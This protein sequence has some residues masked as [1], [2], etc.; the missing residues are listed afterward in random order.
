MSDQ[1]IQNQIN[2]LNNV[3]ALAEHDPSYYP[4]ILDSV[5]S[6]AERKELSLRQWCS[7]LF[8]SALTSENVDEE[9]KRGFCLKLVDSVVNLLSD[10]DLHLQRNCI[11]LS[12]IIYP[13]GFIHVA[14]NPSEKSL[15]SQLEKMKA[16]I[17]SLWD[18]SHFGVKAESIK[19]AQQ[20]IAIQMFNNDN[21]NRD[22]RL[23][24]NAPKN[25]GSSNSFSLSSVPPNHPLIKPS[26]EA[27]AQGLLDR[28][29][30]VFTSPVFKS[31]IIIATLFALSALMKTRPSTA[32]KIIPTVLGFNFWTREAQA[33]SEH[34]AEMQ[35]RFV[36]KGLR[37]FVL[38]TVK[39]VGNKFEHMVHGYLND[40]GKPGYRVAQAIGSRGST[41]RVKREPSDYDNH[42][43]KKQIAQPLKEQSPPV[44]TLP[45]A[46]S[47]AKASSPG[48]I[49]F[50][51]NS[52]IQSFKDLYSLVG[53]GSASENF[54]V[55]Q[56]NLDMAI[57]IAMASIAAANPQIYSKA[58]DTVR[59]RFETWNKN[60]YNDM[61]DRYSNS[62]YNNG[63]SGPRDNPILENDLSPSDKDAENDQPSAETIAAENAE[64]PG[65][66]F[67]SDEEDE[68]D[69]DG[70]GFGDVYGENSGKAFVLPTPSQLNTSEKVK[71]I[72][73]ILVRMISYEKATEAGEEGTNAIIGEITDVN[74]TE[75]ELGLN[76]R[77]AVREWKKNTWVALISRLLTRGFGDVISNEKLNPTYTKRPEYQ[78]HVKS[79]ESITKFIREKL[80]KYC[81]E[82][83]WDRLDIALE[84][85]N[86]EWFHEF[87]RLDSS[88][89]PK[90][91]DGENSVYFHY[92]GLM[93]DSIIPLVDHRY[94]AEFLRLLS[95][96]PEFNKELIWR[97]KS[98]CN[99]PYRFQIGFVALTYLVRFKPPAKDHS[100]DLLEELY[101][102][103]P[104]SREPSMKLLKAYRPQ[105]LE[106]VK[107][108]EDGK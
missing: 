94:R 68:E 54:N 48:P 25:P 19:F 21:A 82:S 44:S 101:V 77:S 64:N 83:L 59:Q 30:S 91:K 24:R 100:L 20:V 35:Y 63:T 106:K 85:L 14:L 97:L 52:Q 22:P 34:E 75:Q 79:V 2:E 12:A 99:D 17:F 102:S 104:E 107:V 36:E 51:P 18:S 13:V 43:Q 86:E 98:L 55:T 41:K 28:V 74:S 96:L 7:E 93:M 53:Q 42:S 72:D 103:N 73:S 16:I 38:H 80:F 81:Q 87:V 1:S 23:A 95:D 69:E 46:P 67:D 11:M 71:T 57:N 92:V 5:L 65:T 49:E 56:F 62:R 89:Q 58:I 60:K 33:D 108:E 26:L 37:L 45:V 29:L 76:R 31:Q 50:R 84:W 10:N 6:I 47:S 88:L 66:P 9:S 32:T 27:E 3:K 105:F 90:S 39:T 78:R 70:D 61:S 40:L 4:Q 8:I 15:W